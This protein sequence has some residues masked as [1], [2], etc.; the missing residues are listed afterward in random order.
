M[1]SRL[2][3]SFASFRRLVLLVAVFLFVA[4]VLRTPTA[5][6][7]EA[8]TPPPPPVNNKIPRNRLP[9]EWQEF[10]KWDI[11][12]NDPEHYPPYNAYQDRDYDP[13]R[14]EAFRQCVSHELASGDLSSAY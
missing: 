7:F 8:G 5:P 4:Y 1:A 3:R 12:T 10:L 2:G 14:W 13:N 9:E 6:W 11:P